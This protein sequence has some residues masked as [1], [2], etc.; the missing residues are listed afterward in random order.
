MKR[1]LLISSLTLTVIL[2]YA[3]VARVKGYYPFPF[4]QLYYVWRFDQGVSFGGPENIIDTNFMFHIK[5]YSVSKEIKS[6]CPVPHIL[7]IA[8]KSDTLLLPLDY[9]FQGKLHVQIYRQGK[10]I[11]DEVTS[12]AINRY[13]HETQNRMPSKIY[14]FDLL[15]I[16]FPLKGKAYKDIVVQVAVLN[17]DTELLKYTDS[18][19]LSMVPDLRIE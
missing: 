4:R 11:Y 15:K 3:L 2:F 12:E 13:E 18:V 10:L 1:I 5:E 16:P 9:K 14:A 7:A 8:L 6:S 19:I 17:P